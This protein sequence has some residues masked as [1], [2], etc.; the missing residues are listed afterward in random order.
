[1]RRNGD[2]SRLV[3]ARVFNA[4]DDHGLT[5]AGLSRTTGI[6]RLRLATCRLCLS[7]L[8]VTEIET[9]ADALG[10]SVLSLVDFEAHR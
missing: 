8:L 2:Y 6:S 7:P 4:V 5:M 3:A 10:I 1:M 9:I